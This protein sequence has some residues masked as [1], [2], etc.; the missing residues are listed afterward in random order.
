MKLTC[1]ICN[2]VFD[3]EEYKIAERLGSLGYMHLD[4]W[5]KCPKCKYT[6]AFGKE[7]SDAKPIYWRPKKLPYTFRKQVE[8][9]FLKHTPPLSCP[10]CGSSLELHKIWIHTWQKSVDIPNGQ[11]VESQASEVVRNAFQFIV[12]NSEGKIGKYFIPAGIMSQW[13][14]TN[15]KCKYVRYVTL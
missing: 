6:P 2:T 4:I 10:F 12:Q 8:N 1:P 11:A 3:D 5:V 15:W 7:L 9:A 14:C 13:K